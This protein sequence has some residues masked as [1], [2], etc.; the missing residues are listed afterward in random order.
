VRPVAAQHSIKETAAVHRA[1]AVL[2]IAGRIKAHPAG[3]LAIRR[4]KPKTIEQARQLIE[5]YIFFYNHEW[6]Q[7][8]TKLTP[9]EKR[10][11]FARE[12]QAKSGNSAVAESFRLNFVGKYGIVNTAVNCT[13]GR[14]SVVEYRLPKPWVASSNLVARSSRIKPFGELPEGVFLFAGQYAGQ[15]R[16]EVL[17]INI[18]IS[19]NIRQALGGHDEVRLSICIGTPV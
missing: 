9:L 2:A 6:I 16:C 10:R 11:Q 4:H 17:A 1:A 13:C 5:N 14:S 7:L 12:A 3:C 15:K 19:Q 8:K 18:Y